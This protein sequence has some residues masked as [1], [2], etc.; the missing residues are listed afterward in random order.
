M[1]LQKLS[2][3][4]LCCVYQCEYSTLTS[5]RC[6]Q[7]NVCREHFL[8]HDQ[9][10]RSKFNRLT[11]QIDSIAQ[12]LESFDI[13]RILVDIAT[14]LHQWRCD[15]F[16]LIEKFYR[17]KL[18]EVYRFVE[19]NFHQKEKKCDEFQT[20][21]IEMIN[22]Q[23]ATSGELEHLTK[24]IEHLKSELDD[25]ENLSIELHVNPLE[26]RQNQI[27]M[28]ISVSKTTNLD[29]FN[30][31]AQ[32][33][34]RVPLSSSVVSSNEQHL[35]IHQNS[36]LVLLNKSLAIV[37]HCYWPFDWIRDMCWSSK[38]RRFFLITSNK[39]YLF[40]EETLTIEP[41]D[42][43]EGRSWNSC[44][45]SETSLFLSKELWNS[46]VEQY[47]IYPTIRFV[48][49]WK[50]NPVFGYQQ[51]I[52]SMNIVDNTIVLALND[53]VK[54]KFLIEFR[55]TKTFECLRSFSLNLI[56]S[57]RKLRCCSFDRKRWLI[58]DWGNSTLILLNDDGQ[59]EKKIQYD[60]EFH[61]IARWT[62]NTF[63]V[64]TNST[65]NFHKL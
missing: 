4:Q 23:R 53:R 39:I 16:E 30:G 33:I 21:L 31:I 57:E 37:R 55:S 52:D 28:E 13:E 14:K 45:C 56:H 18:N 2:M 9:T 32:Q 25:L 46:T 6:C 65:W 27:S 44:T 59:I 7:K 50:T 12:R 24:S 10:I 1:L 19:E 48:K 22:L 34:E 51:R 26:I 29:G 40:D 11:T 3:P 35:L 36:K 41:L 49:L 43:I 64:T 54:N 15:S 5:C 38:L 63:V 58:A 62:S 47:E 61:H 17:E 20:K 60:S 8:Q 42:Q